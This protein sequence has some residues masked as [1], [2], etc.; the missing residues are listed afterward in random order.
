MCFPVN[1]YVNC[2]C[3]GKHPETCDLFA[4]YVILLYVSKCMVRLTY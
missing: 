3:K 1:L 4:P 2:L